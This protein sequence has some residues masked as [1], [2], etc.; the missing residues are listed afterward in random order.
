M[1]IKVVQVM[2]DRIKEEIETKQK[3]NKLKQSL[4]AM[5]DR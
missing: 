5:K 4:E 3:Q 1:E 2:I